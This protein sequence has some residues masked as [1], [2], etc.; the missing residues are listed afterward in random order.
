MTGKVF[1]K[2]SNVSQINQPSHTV[3][4]CGTLK[5]SQK[6]DSVWLDLPEVEN[7]LT[8]MH[9]NSFFTFVFLYINHLLILN[10]EKSRFFKFWPLTVVFKWFKPVKTGRF[11]PDWS[12][13]GQPW[14]KYI[15]TG[16]FLTADVT[17]SINKS[18][19]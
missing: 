11:K 6:R 1:N 12:F 16:W 18:T 10:T 7:E 9:K 17:S 14:S 8:L 13:S 19:F 5:D 3:C 2:R 15:Y 4:T